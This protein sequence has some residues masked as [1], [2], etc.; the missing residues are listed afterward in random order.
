MR[1]EIFLTEMSMEQNEISFASIILTLH[2]FF[3]FPDHNLQSLLASKS[4]DTNFSPI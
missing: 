4:V 2:T 1:T 3:G